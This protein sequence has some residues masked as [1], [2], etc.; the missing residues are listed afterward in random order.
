MTANDDQV[1][2][3]A[4]RLRTLGA[5]DLLDSDPEPSFDTITRL[6]AENFDAPISLVS[7]VDRDRQWFKSC[8]GL[9]EGETP[10]DIAFCDHVIRSDEVLLVPDAL[11]DPRFADNPLVVG[12]PHIRTYVGAP[13]IHPN[14]AR[15]GSLCAVFDRPTPVSDKQIRTLQGLAATTVELMVARRD[16]QNLRRMVKGREKLNQ[17]IR[18]QSDWLSEIA[19]IASIGGWELDLVE[20]KVIWTE[21]T[22]RIH[23]VDEFYEPD[24]E[25]AIE[26]YAP[27]F[28]D[29]VIENLERAISNQTP[30]D[31][32]AEMVTAQGRSIW[33]RSVGKPRVVNGVVVKVVGAFQDMS[34]AHERQN[35]LIADRWRMAAILDA[36]RV[37]TWEWDA[38]TDLVKYNDI[39]CE[40]LGRSMSEVSPTFEQWRA[41]VHPDDL[42]Q[43]EDRLRAHLAGETERYAVD[44]RMKHADGRWVWISSTGRIVERAADGS[45]VKIVGAHT[46]ISERIEITEKLDEEKRKAEAAN[47]AKSRFLANMSHEIRTPLNGVIALAGAV[48]KTDLDSKQSEMISLIQTSGDALERIL[49]DI[50]DLSKIEA[51]GLDITTA[52]FDLRK[53]VEAASELMRV[54]ADDKG[55]RFTIRYGETAEGVFEG[56]AVRIRQVLANLTSNAIKFTKTGE[57]CVWV[58]VA[59]GDP[60]ALKIRV[61]DTGIGFDAETGAR[62]FNRF[63]Q[64]DA[65]ITRSFGG[66]GLGLAISKALVEMM[67]GRIG[68]ESQPGHG[69]EFWFDLPLERTMPLE[70]YRRRQA[71]EAGGDAPNVGAGLG[72]L[73]VLVAEDNPNNQ[74]VIQLV[75][76]QLG[77]SLEIVG[78]GAKAV[79]TFTSRPFDIVLMDMQMPV[80][81]GVAATRRIRA[82]EREEGR[83]RTPIAMLSA[84]AMPDHIDASLEAG[85]DEHIAKPF[86][87]ASLVD[88]IEKLIVLH[89]THDAAKVS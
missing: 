85:C 13:L 83:P 55:L 62:L 76:E 52:P 44:I 54:R 28:R 20:K 46:D 42:A 12:P 18:A 49:S 24:L 26:F 79:E 43:A 51:G 63:Q 40:M 57:V 72:P 10:R 89:G 33:V 41:L 82:F 71:S 56:D 9:S 61:V 27:E 84:N 1:A 86:T 30:F 78:D 8:V 5:L 2:A 17:K 36:T 4:A 6:V 47:V 70:D 75:L 66:T 22:R 25:T 58:D 35:L 64:A 65:G 39:W 88:G 19:E 73:R 59:E 87:P 45:P 81:D 67:G 16:R 23:E 21:G 38:T 74:R 34:E 60:S 53:A 7:L 68:A 80:M 3:E 15:L 29:T 32:Q 69:S 50:L 48:A 31:F 11:V 37:G 77:L 14:G